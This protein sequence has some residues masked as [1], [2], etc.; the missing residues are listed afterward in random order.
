MMLVVGVVR[1]RVRLALGD[2]VE[3]MKSSFCDL[4]WPLSLYMFLNDVRP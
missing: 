3:M 2:V 1:L 4:A